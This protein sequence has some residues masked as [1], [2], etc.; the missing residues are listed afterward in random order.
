MIW[1]S[2][3]RIGSLLGA[4]FLGL[5][6]VCTAGVTLRVWDNGGNAADDVARIGDRLQSNLS[7]SPAF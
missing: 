5:G 3:G 6:M 2:A 4:M 7:R 1:R